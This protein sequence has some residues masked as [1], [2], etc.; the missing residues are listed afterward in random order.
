MFRIQPLNDEQKQLLRFK[1]KILDMNEKK[2]KSKSEEKDSKE[3]TE[4]N[5]KITDEAY[6]EDADWLEV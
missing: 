3:I 1:R 6:Q 2:E 4:V 5:K